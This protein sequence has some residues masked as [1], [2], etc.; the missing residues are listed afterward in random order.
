MLVRQLAAICKY[1]EL[2]SH[3]EYSLNEIEYNEQRCIWGLRIENDYFA[4][5]IQRP[6]IVFLTAQ[7]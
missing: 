6:I 5:L 1:L 2:D 7:E 3:I 4:G